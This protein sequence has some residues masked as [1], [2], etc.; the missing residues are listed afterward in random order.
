MIV[1]YILKPNGQ[2]DEITELRKNLKLRHYQTA[3]VILDLEN[4]CCVVNNIN[5]DAS[6]D[7]MLELYKKMLGDQLTPHLPQESP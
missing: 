4:K 2:Y 3:K 6:F 7:M 1:N 5:R